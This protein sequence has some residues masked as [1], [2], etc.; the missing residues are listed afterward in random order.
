MVSVV[1]VTMLNPLFISTCQCR[2]YPLGY[3]IATVLKVHAHVTVAKIKD[4]CDYD[5]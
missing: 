1:S 3:V 5:R 4:Q 2:L